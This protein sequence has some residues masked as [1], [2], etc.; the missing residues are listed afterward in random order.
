MIIPGVT[1]TPAL[2]AWLR[3]AHDDGQR[4]LRVSQ[5]SNLWSGVPTWIE[6]VRDGGLAGDEDLSPT[7][8]QE[9]RA[10]LAA[11]AVE[12]LAMPVRR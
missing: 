12:S 11:H 6:V 8:E 7:E 2:A 4:N 3:A 5:I 10:L 1:L 9:V